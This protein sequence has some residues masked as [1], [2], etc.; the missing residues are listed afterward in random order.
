MGQHQIGQLVDAARR[1]EPALGGFQGERVALAQ[2]RQA[3]RDARRD[4]GRSVLG[5]NRPMSRAALTMGP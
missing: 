3:L 5:S 1:E 2:T 4:A